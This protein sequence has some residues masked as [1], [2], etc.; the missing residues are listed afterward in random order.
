MWRSREKVA[1]F[2]HAHIPDFIGNKQ[3]KSSVDVTLQNSFFMAEIS[4]AEGLE[5]ARDCPVLVLLAL[6]ARGCSI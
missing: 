2:K 4:V 3:V 5:L 1:N 6:A